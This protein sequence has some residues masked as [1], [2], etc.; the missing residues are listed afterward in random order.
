MKHSCQSGCRKQYLCGVAG[1]VVILRVARRRNL[2]AC[3]YCISSKDA[4]LGSFVLNQ[5]ALVSCYAEHSTDSSNCL[6][7]SLTVDALGAS[8]D[9]TLVPKIPNATSVVG[10]TFGEDR[11]VPC[12]DGRTVTGLE[13][14][15]GNSASQS[16]WCSTKSGFH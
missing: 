12:E 4:P 11:D 14:A 16:V 1:A 2:R 3:L 6:A 7:N 9:T 10:T 8:P 13:E 15:V 5:T